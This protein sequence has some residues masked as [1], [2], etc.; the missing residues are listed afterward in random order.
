MWGDLCVN[1]EDVLAGCVQEELTKRWVFGE[2]EKHEG[3]K[4]FEGDDRE[5]FC[6]WCWCWLR[7]GCV[8][9]VLLLLM[10]VLGVNEGPVVANGNLEKSPPCSKRAR[11]GGE[12]QYMTAMKACW[13]V[14]KEP[15]P[16]RGWTWMGF[17]KAARLER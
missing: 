12:R 2:F 17:W 7:G 8:C 9:G 3:K 5:E 16:N 1:V 10:C 14:M 4:D 6:G 15:P 13:T 11:W